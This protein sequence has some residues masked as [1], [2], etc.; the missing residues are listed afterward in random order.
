MVAPASERSVPCG[1]CQGQVPESHFR[2]GR[3]RM[4]QEVLYCASCTSAAEKARVETAAFKQSLSKGFYACSKC[5]SPMAMKD[6]ETNNVVF[7]AGN[8]YCRD[9]SKDLRSILRPNGQRVSTRQ[10]AVFN[11][12]A[13]GA[14][15]GGSPSRRLSPS[16]VSNISGVGTVSGRQAVQQPA[17]QGPPCHLCDK[18]A[19]AIPGQ[20]LPLEYQGNIYCGA[21]RR[22]IDSMIARSQE[23]LA[24]IS[25]FECQRCHATVRA[26]DVIEGRA[27]RYRG[28]ILCAGC[29][30]DVDGR[31]ASSPEVAL[32]GAP[33][34]AMPVQAQPSAPCARCERTIAGLDIRLG[35]VLERDG[36][37]FCAK[38]KVDLDAARGI[39]ERK[40][41][42]AVSC[43]HCGR[44]I[45]SKEIQERKITYHEGNVFCFGCAKDPA[46]ILLGHS[47]DEQAVG[48]CRMC[49]T[50]IA[51]GARGQCPACQ[52]K[53]DQL[54]KDSLE[55]S[56]ELLATSALSYPCDGQGCSNPI[57]EEDLESGRAVISGD[58]SL[59]HACAAKLKPKKAPARCARC[60]KALEPG[61]A[62]GS[63]CGACQEKS[64]EDAADMETALKLSS[65]FTLRCHQC[66]RAIQAE[67]LENGKA[68]TVHG[69]LVCG[70]C[71]YKNQPKA[72][73]PGA[74]L[75]KVCATCDGALVG[76]GVPYGDKR[77]CPACQGIL[78][79]LLAASQLPATVNANC[80][81]CKKPAKGEGAL[82]IDGQPFCKS[83]RR[84]ADFLILYTIRAK[85]T[86]GSRGGGGS[87]LPILVAI[88]SALAIF[89]IAWGVFSNRDRSGPDPLAIKPP[90]ITDK[91]D[92]D[93]IVELPPVARAMQLVRS[94]SRNYEQAQSV[95]EQ[96]AKLQQTSN[97]PELGNLLAKA[98]AARN[99]YAYGIA[100]AL[101]T[102]AEA[103]AR[104]GRLDD[105]LKE[106]DKF[107]REL[108]ETDPGRDVTKARDR[109]QSLQTCIREAN[110][111]LI[112]PEPERYLKM[113]QLMASAGAGLCSFA[114]TPLGKRVDEQRRLLRN[115]VVVKNTAAANG[116]EG[117]L[118]VPDA[119][120]KAKAQ[121]EKNSLANAESFYN[122]ALDGDPDNIDAIAGLARIALEY[123]RPRK[124]QRHVERLRRIAGK[125]PD[126][127]VLV[128][129]LALTDTDL[130]GHARAKAAIEGLSAKELGP[131]GRALQA[132][133]DLGAPKVNGQHLSFAGDVDTGQA[134]LGEEAASKATAIFGVARGDDRVLVLIFKTDNARSAFVAKLGR[135]LN[136]DD[137]RLP[138]CQAIALV[139]PTSAGLASS[140][141]A[142][143][144]ARV[145]GSPSW[146]VATLPLVVVRETPP[147]S[148]KEPPLAEIEQAS[149][150]ALA[151]NPALVWGAYKRV[152]SALENNK[153]SVLATYVTNR[154]LGDAKKA[155]AELDASLGLR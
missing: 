85:R 131:R 106:L 49:G 40:A 30:K 149:L 62:P 138:G 96:I 117:K 130:N 147:S 52:G 148:D 53:I 61:A 68:V 39:R 140:V 137:G 29:S 143:V 31:S 55:K 103:L 35:K 93:K 121:E 28:Q 44:S 73:A 114:E 88:S 50:A 109:Y 128:G 16:Q 77:I 126:V 58:K 95:V 111:L 79:N 99:A 152:A 118:P 120:A 2:S 67:E 59:C 76:A 4:Y 26:R 51:P 22:E 19:V 115:E 94:Q 75:K 63:F 97:D 20:P 45:S 100:T 123:D 41:A 6:I 124:A 101:L 72:A 83:C 80:K 139:A 151:G 65:E 110:S 86:G 11:S 87:K 112:R 116:G 24:R 102:T 15:I 42:K 105:A 133:L 8:L 56:S 21:C 37:L 119:L 34:K 9:C 32:A 60:R 17:P 47:S 14:G 82:F 129:C 71:R 23:D 153:Q 64:A 5:E 36:K 69:K 142:A 90:K 125:R 12:Q 135:A 54:Q 136:N 57:T 154:R 132:I 92:D 18:P 43:S 91:K 141:I 150:S 122:M 155:R 48:A 145:D 7:F 89:A 127:R 3:A 113:D 46:K 146:I 134:P 1:V 84:A 10:S 81:S 78:E 38:C 13:S 74:V 25:T 144:A 108:I 27:I 33:K 107:P 70:T 66:Q 104:Q 98:V